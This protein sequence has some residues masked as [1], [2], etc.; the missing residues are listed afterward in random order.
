MTRNE[1]LYRIAAA[2]ENGSKS[3]F[4]PM[5]QAQAEKK[6]HE[7]LDATNWKSIAAATR[8]MRNKRIANSL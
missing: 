8:Y 7:V 2:I 1:K 5:T 4:F 6:A 3:G